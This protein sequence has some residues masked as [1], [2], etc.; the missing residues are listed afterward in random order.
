[1]G[2]SSDITCHH[3]R[4]HQERE[5]VGNFK[6]P[7]QRWERRPCRVSITTSA[8]IHGVAIPYGIYDPPK[9]VA[10]LSWAFPTTLPHSPAHAIAH[11][12][13]Q[14]GSQ[15][16]SGSRRILIR[17]IRAAATA[18]AAMPG[19][20]APVSTGQLFCPVC[21]RGPLSTCASKWNPIEHRLFSEVS[22][23][24]AGEPLD[25]YQKILNYT[26]P[27]KLKPALPSLLTWI[28]AT[29]LAASSQLPTNSPH[30]DCSAMKPCPSGTTPSNLNC[31][32]VLERRLSRI[33]V[34]EDSSKPM[35]PAAAMSSPQ[36][37]ERR[38]APRHPFIASAEETT[39][40]QEHDG[41][42]RV[43]ELSLKGCYL[44]TPKS[45]F[46]KATKIKLVIFLRRRYITVHAV[47]YP[48]PNMGMGVVFSAVEPNSWKF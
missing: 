37:S 1:V 47:I 44:D 28:A 19:R 13:Y 24:W 2:A 32:V 26:R 23:N 25:S 48:Q 43:S 17:P 46:L 30:C 20:R 12:W 36:K 11:W 41:S 21:H 33:T 31:E 38:G 4:G 29:I 6:N 42:A 3:Q 34:R 14:E 15:R 5:L 8:R 27:Q 39:W 35:M 40:L 22:R 9:T 10:L 7:G 16:Y 45:L 18:I